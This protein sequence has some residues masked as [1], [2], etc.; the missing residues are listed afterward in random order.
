M[1][2]KVT[3]M[4]PKVTPIFPKTKFN[5]WNRLRLEKYIASGLHKQITMREIPICRLFS[6]WNIYKSSHAPA[7]Q[8]SIVS[9]ATAEQK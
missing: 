7:E 1:L 8:K 6:L 5:F 3:P 2:P 9:Q 4:L